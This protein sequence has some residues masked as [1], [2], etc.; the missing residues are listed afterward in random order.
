MGLLRYLKILLT[1]LTLIAVTESRA[2][3]QPFGEYQVKAVFLLNLTNFIKW[4][5]VSFAS[6]TAP[7]RIV[8]L[9]DDPFKIVLDKTVKGES[10]QGHPIIIERHSFRETLPPCHILFIS[11]SLK[12]KVPDI[13]AEIKQPN[14]LTVADHPG[15]CRQGGMVNLLFKNNRVQIEAN[16]KKAEQAG[17]QI[18]SKLLRISIPF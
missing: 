7:F 14:V 5:E 15:F 1:L 13:L 9:G 4:P 11:P 17:L 3:V 2:E 8:V 16:A 6:T 10:V 18:N 12:R